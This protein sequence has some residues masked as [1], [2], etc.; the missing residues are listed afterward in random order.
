M[1]I[2]GRQASRIL[3]DAGISRQQSRR[4]LLAGLAGPGTR[5]ANAVVYDEQRVRDLSAWTAMDPE[6]V[7]AESG[8]RLLV[9][10]LGPG[11]EPRAEWTWEQRVESVRFQPHLGFPARAQLRAYLGHHERLACVATVCG[12]PVLVAELAAFDHT[13]DGRLD[14]VLEPAGSWAALVERRRLVTGP[15]PPWLVMGEQPYLG[16]AAR[17]RQRG[18]SV[19]AG[20]ST[21]WSR[22]A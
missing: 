11:H 3:A 19:G 4:V 7:R 1:Q 21:I 20:R 16:R 6:A 22:W 8:S 9:I 5:L 15:G 10:R 2:T 12:Y 14:L 13:V 17:A 18:E